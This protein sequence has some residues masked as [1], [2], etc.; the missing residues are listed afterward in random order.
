MFEGQRFAILAMFLLWVRHFPRKMGEDDQNPNALRNFSSYKGR[1][2]KKF[3][4][5]FQ[6]YMGGGG[7]KAV[8]KK[9]K[10]K[11]ISF[12]DGF[13]KLIEFLTDPV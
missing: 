10:S 4:E 7:V 8:W 13:P 5:A 9:S 2:F 11:Q 3:L 1:F 12:L 6:K